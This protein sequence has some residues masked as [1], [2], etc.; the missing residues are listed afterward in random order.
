MTDQLAPLVAPRPQIGG[1]LQDI[2]NLTPE[3]ISAVLD[4]QRSHGTRFGEA[5]VALGF[6][7]RE[8]VLWAL[9]KQFNYSY[10]SP[11]EKR[12]FSPDLVA[13][14]KPF[15]SCAEEFR[16]LRTN[17]LQRGA[18]K[19]GAHCLAITSP[20]QGD[21]KSFFSA[22]LAVSFSQT[23]RKTLLL[24]ADMRTLR[25]SSMMSSAGDTGL[26]AVL[27]RGSD[28][29]ILRPYEEL[30]DFFVLPAGVAPPNPLELLQST[31]FEE[32]L[33]DLRQKFE[34]V[35]IDTPASDLC[36]D[37]GVIA[38]KADSCLV[39]ARRH[40]SEARQLQ[41]H[42][43]ALRRGGTNVVGLAMNDLHSA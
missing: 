30:P 41:A 38:S 27:S 25:L 18:V 2:R 13:A 8:D 1:L 14:A 42:I 7:G 5:A 34:V 20:Q 28:A 21:G 12:T 31:V 35:I 23:G 37:G 26:S 43:A 9:A 36:A 22:N 39:I 29:T 40:R 24:D 6:I 3:Q 10:L 15:S 4:Y 16:K 17:L 33:L 19:Q 32:L 11:Q